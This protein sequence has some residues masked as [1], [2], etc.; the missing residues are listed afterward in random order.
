MGPV[1]ARAQ[2]ALGPHGLHSGEESVLGPCGEGKGTNRGKEG[3]GPPAEPR[4][5]QPEQQPGAKRGDHVTGAEGIK[6]GSP[7]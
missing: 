1:C 5:G 2:A 3:Q 4:V 7:G 6:L